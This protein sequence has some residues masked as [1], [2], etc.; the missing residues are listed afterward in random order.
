MRSFPYRPASRHLHHHLAPPAF[1]C[2]KREDV[3]PDFRGREGELF[4]GEH[5]ILHAFAHPVGI[6]DPSHDESAIGHEDKGLA[7]FSR[8]RDAAPQT[9]V[10]H[11]ALLI[12][13][14]LQRTTVDDTRV[15][16]AFECRAEYAAAALL[17]RRE[18]CQTQIHVPP[19]YVGTAIA[20]PHHDAL[21]VRLVRDFHERV[22]GKRT[23]RGSESMHIEALAERRALSV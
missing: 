4:A 8:A 22:M 2:P 18:G 21:P 12:E 16:D 13:N 23:M 7:Q 3:A 6:D 17:D 5:P 14:F 11:D 10:S 1:G 20:A 15:P 9:H 19:L